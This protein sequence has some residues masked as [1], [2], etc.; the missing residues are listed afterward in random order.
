MTTSQPNLL[1]PAIRQLQ[2]MALTIPGIKAAPEMLVP[3][4]KELPFVIAVPNDG[5]LDMLANSSK[6]MHTIYW[7]AHVS[8][9]RLPAAIEDTLD[10][11]HQMDFLLK[12]DLTI[13]GTVQTVIFPTRYFI[14][15]MEWGGNRF[16]HVGVR[17]EV[18]IKIHQALS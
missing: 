12:N 4:L 15:R 14:G 17:M 2:K 10:I 3:S 18:E 16:A 5:Q 6:N 7:E 11:L 1:T 9:N 8:P 13:G